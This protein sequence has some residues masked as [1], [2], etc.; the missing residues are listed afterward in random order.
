[1]LQIAERAQLA[2]AAY[3]MLEE[4]GASQQRHTVVGGQPCLPALVCLRSLATSV[5]ILCGAAA[6][7]MREKGR[8]PA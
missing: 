7:G 4:E 2:D 8:A 6:S 5:Q 3:L 1:L